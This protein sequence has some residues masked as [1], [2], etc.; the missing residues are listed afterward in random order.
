MSLEV[1][2]TLIQYCIL[3]TL[4]MVDIKGKIGSY[5][6]HGGL[7]EWVNEYENNVQQTNAVVFIAIRSQATLD[8]KVYSTLYLHTLMGIEREYSITSLHF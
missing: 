8:R 4:Q 3:Y 2:N 6:G 5:P 1:F 7:T